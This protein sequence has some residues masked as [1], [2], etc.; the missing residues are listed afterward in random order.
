MAQRGVLDLKRRLAPQA[1]PERGEQHETH[2]SHGP[3]G[4]Q[5]DARSSMYRPRT[6]FPVGTPV[7]ALHDCAISRRHGILRTSRA[8]PGGF[9]RLDTFRKK[10]TIFNPTDKARLDGYPDHVCCSIQYPNAWFFRKARESQRL[11]PD[12]VVLLIDARYLW[13]PGTKFCPRNAAAEQGQLVRGGIVAFDALF[14]ETVE[15]LRTYRRGPGHPDFLPTDEQAEVL[16]PDRIGRGDVSGVVVR[17]DEQAAREISRLE[18]A[19]LTG[20]RVVII[21]EFFDPSALSRNLR[22]G[23]IPSEREY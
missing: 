10:T 15:G 2:G 16:I 22:S 6:R 1:R 9:S 11:F 13:Q 19:R 4:Y 3:G 23:W 18:L 20:P 14:A 12:W 17:D 5:A 21:P 7:G 8:I